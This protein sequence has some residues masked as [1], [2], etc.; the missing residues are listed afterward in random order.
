MEVIE[1]VAKRMHD[2]YEASAVKHGW[3]T[4]AQCQVSFYDLPEENKLTML[5]AAEAAIQ[6]LI[7]VDW[8][9]PNYDMKNK[10]DSRY[11]DAENLAKAMLKQLLDN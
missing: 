5:D 10:F 11:V 9:S 6:A 4:Q 3:K 2:T 7:D 1:K 8:P